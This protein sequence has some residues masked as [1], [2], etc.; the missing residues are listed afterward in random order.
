[1]VRGNYTGS[2][3]L[4]GQS[5]S[6]LGVSLILEDRF[7]TVRSR[8]D[9][10]G[11]YP[12]EKVDVERTSGDRF[13]FKI[14]NEEFDFIAS[15]PVRFF[16]DAVPEIERAGVSS[17]GAKTLFK[18]LLGSLGIRKEEQVEEETPMR[19]A[20]E[21]ARKDQPP[22]RPKPSRQETERRTGFSMP[23]PVGR[24]SSADAFSPSTSLPPLGRTRAAGGSSFQ[25]GF[26]P[27]LSS[28]RP[29]AK[30]DTTGPQPA[31]SDASSPPSPGFPQPSSQYPVQAPN[32]P[33]S[34]YV[35]PPGIYSPPYP[36]VPQPVE[37]GEIPEQGI[38][39][40]AS[41]RPP[42]P[43]GNQG[44][45]VPDYPTPSSP[46][47]EWVDYST[48]S[49]LKPDETKAGGA[50]VSDSKTQWEEVKP[51]FP[52]RDSAVEAASDPVVH[53]EASSVGG[54]V[55]SAAG[56]FSSSDLAQDPAWA[57]ER[58]LVEEKVSETASRA[59]DLHPDLEGLVIRLETAVTQVHEG[60]LDPPQALAMA[61][62]VQA[63]CDTLSVAE[64]RKD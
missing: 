59:R 7:L 25:S 16:Y 60:I 22:P 27:P 33:Y 9:T 56:S 21:L 38:F 40:G 63:M 29:L 8:G 32:D 46:T 6:R 53:L 49:P 28:S 1:M 13:R 3:G 23:P 4:P 64:K 34:T 48:P 58:R 15:D 41:D 19:K 26:P 2:L 36:P 12:I 43:P 11:E 17:T 52:S 42:F 24:G 54:S 37:G 55:E 62:L 47:P 57:A 50:S 30:R 10:L 31:V 51:Y 18:S 39:E 61:S 45:P 35:P 14:G 5:G 20:V 44:A